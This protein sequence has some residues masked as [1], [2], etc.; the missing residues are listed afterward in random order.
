[1]KTMFGGDGIE[2]TSTLVIGLL[3]IIL[4]IFALGFILGTRVH[5]S[6]PCDTELS[7]EQIAIICDDEVSKKCN[8]CCP[9]IESNCDCNCEDAV[10]DAI[11]QCDCN[12]SNT[13]QNRCIVKEGQNLAWQANPAFRCDLASDRNHCESI[14]PLDVIRDQQYILCK[15]EK[16]LLGQGAESC[17]EPHRLCKWE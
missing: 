8:T 1:M 12:P 11:A 17:A 6:S 15:A 4:F 3:F 5:G 14:I 16:D 2:V 13:D 9:N 10:N 7:K